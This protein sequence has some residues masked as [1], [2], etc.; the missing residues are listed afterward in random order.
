M[1]GPT[2]SE[3]EPV[4]CNPEEPI[5][6]RNRAIFYL[7]TM[8][9][10]EAIQVLER[11][12]YTDTS[13][14]FRHEICYALGQMKSPEAIPF[15]TSILDNESETDVTRHEASEALAA[16]GDASVYPILE[17]YRNC[18]IQPIA[19]TCQISLDRLDWLKSGEE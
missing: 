16:I 15:L 12:F 5:S 3:L 6:K 13:E 18:P 14:L 4:I 11:A 9:T 2:I 7:R 1:E 19:E 17:K 8:E 10:S